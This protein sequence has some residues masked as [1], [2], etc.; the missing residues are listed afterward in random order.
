[1]M[2]GLSLALLV[3]TSLCAC[4]TPSAV[5]ASPAPAEKVEAK[6][7]AAPAAKL[8]TSRAL[9]M[10]KLPGD[11]GVERLVASLQRSAEKNPAKVD[12]W[13]L[14][15]RAWVRK[16]RES[17]D[18]GFYVNAN[19][20]AE[21]AL[22]VS[23]EDKLAYDLQGLVLLNDHKFRDAVD[24]ANKI[25]AKNPDD[26]MAYGSLSDALL[27]LG[28]FD[29][30]A[31]A[32]QKMMDIKPNLPS[33]SRASYFRWLAGDDKAALEYARLAIDSGRDP[34][35]PE[36]RAWELVQAAMIFW[37]KGDLDGADAGFGKALDG[38]SE[39]PP[40]LVGRGRV[41]MARGDAARAA[42]LLGRAY[43]QSPLPETAWLLGDARAA[44][45]DAAGAARAFASLEKDGRRGDPRT[46]ALFFATKNQNAPEALALATLEMQSRGDV[47]TEDAYAWAAYRA[48]KIDE[49]KRAIDHA[50]RLGTRDARL[51]YHQ[52]AIHIAA[53][54]V[55]AG[56]KLVAT[57]LA[58]NAAFDVDGAREARKL[59]ETKPKS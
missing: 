45:G 19:A 34:K 53:G 27:E 17:S 6:A 55:A 35:D 18:P 57:A 59:L 41:A 25:L 31:D 23:P 11:G 26:A 2:K 3:S 44:A 52:G 51:V 10:A 37:H 5:P 28:R 32:A 13:I 16:A 33:Y 38:V 54:D 20:C 29:E 43:E 15:G 30:A 22:E 14:L 46:L 4:N 36:P 9:A 50:R 42:E 58:T 8:S 7:G 24:L 48:G 40:A 12:F 39:Y 56:R 49:A 21:I 1:M 47:Y